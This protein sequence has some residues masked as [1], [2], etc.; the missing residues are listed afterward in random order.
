MKC[1][2]RDLAIAKLAGGDLS[3]WQ[4]ARL[5]RHLDECSRCA[6]LY[7]E[8]HDQ[9]EV[10]HSTY[11]RTEMN[12]DSPLVDKVLNQID[13][14]KIVAHRHKVSLQ[15]V[16]AAAF[17][18]ALIGAVVLQLPERGPAVSNHSSMSVELNRSVGQHTAAHTM[19]KDTATRHSEVVIRMETNNPE[20]VILWLGDSAG[21]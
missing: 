9:C 12:E 18:L 6:T 19:E 4:A 21:G 10:F 17:A 2:R 8:L 1:E 20:V 15:A 13:N 3:G 5:Q 16:A 11:C 14:R 7:N